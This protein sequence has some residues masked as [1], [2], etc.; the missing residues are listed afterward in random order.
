MQTLQ[1]TLRI[2][3]ENHH[4]SIH[5]RDTLL[6]VIRKLGLT[7]SK[8]G[9]LN[10]DCGACTVNVDDMPMKSCLM[11]AIEAV[12]KDIVTIEG[13]KDTPIQ[14]AFIEK[15]AFQCGYCTSGFLMNAHSLIKNHPDASEEE[16]KN[17]L[18]SNICRCTGYQE[19]EEAVKSVLSKKQ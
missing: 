4:V 2:N 16:I 13:L 6:Y 14:Q 11:L 19:I 9:C 15:F 7:G 3:G 17:W 10:G 12:D 8:P 5:P 1:V 18:K